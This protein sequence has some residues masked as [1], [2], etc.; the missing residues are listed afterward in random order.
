MN[1]GFK[2]VGLITIFVLLFSV[3]SGSIEKEKEIKKKKYILKFN[4]KP[5]S[6]K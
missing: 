6:K 1:S 4:L 2:L 3:M 5:I